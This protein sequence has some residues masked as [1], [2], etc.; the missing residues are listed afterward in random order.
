M[1]ISASFEA[2]A[3]LPPER[4]LKL[5]EAAL[6]DGY[7]PLHSAAFALLADPA[8]LNRPDVLVARYA[9]LPPEL[10]QRM[11]HQKDRFLPAARALLDSEREGDRRAG[12][13]ALFAL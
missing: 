7:S 10:R 6:L 13:S 8:G 1:G 3:G 2:I 9:A 11:S 12:L 5:V 4:R